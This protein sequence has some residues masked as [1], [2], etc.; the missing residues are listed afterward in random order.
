MLYNTTTNV[1]KPRNEIGLFYY[2][3]ELSL[4]YA[5]VINS[6]SEPGTYTTA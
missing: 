1:M 5:Q 6:I 3:Y 2:L 4:F